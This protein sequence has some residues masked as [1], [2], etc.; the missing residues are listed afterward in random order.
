MDP[1]ARNAGVFVT[2]DLR[3]KQTWVWTMST[4]T[5]ARQTEHIRLPRR[6]RRSLKQ[7]SIP[8]S[9]TSCC[10][11]TRIHE[12][13]L[14]TRPTRQNRNEEPFNSYAAGG[15]PTSRD[16]EPA[17]PSDEG[18]CCSNGTRTAFQPSQTQG[19]PENIDDPRA[20]PADVRPSSRR[21]SGL[22]PHLLFVTS[23]PLRPAGKRT[24][25]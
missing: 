15:E 4:P 20:R 11:A 16:P 22:C 1:C 8:K 6:L 23:K 12:R 9:A 5:L 13:R 3:I 17:I 21:K 18:I 2:P 19:T 10:A 7:N 25:T 14:A 24:A